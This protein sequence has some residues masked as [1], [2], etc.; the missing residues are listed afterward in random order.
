LRNSQSLWYFQKSFYSLNT[1]GDMTASEG[2]MAKAIA[3]VPY[4]V[5]YRSM[6][7]IGLLKLNAIVSQ[8]QKVVK[9][10]DIQKQFTDALPGV[11]NA[12]LSA[13]KADPTNYLNWISLGRVYE[14]LVPYKIQGAY[15]S[16]MSSYTEALRYNPKNPGILVMFARLAF[17]NND[18]KTARNYVMQSINMKQNY[19][20]AYFLLSQ[21]E[22]ADKNLKGAIDSVTA[23]SII[24][25]SD[26]SI[27]FQLGILK[28]NNRD[29]LGAID[30]L[31]K[32]LKLSPQYANAKYFLGLSYELNGEREKAIAQFSDLKA[33]N[34]ESKEVE[35]ILTNLVAG[36]S[37]FENAQTKAPEKASKLPVKETTQQ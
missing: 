17:T 34:P 21:I 28:Y 19:L 18:L 20:D 11:I 16:A 9:L 32:S 25:P 29:V 2:F 5:Y 4:D 27:F 24:N 7:E 8:D 37:I 3:T 15:E 12:G 35:A 23:A 36:K 6:S 30:A 22:V 33:S 31:E 14:T 10:E 13:T 1:V 26:P